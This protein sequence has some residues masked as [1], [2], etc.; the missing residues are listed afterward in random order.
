MF[1]RFGLFIPFSRGRL[2]GRVQGAAKPEREG[3]G[4]RAARSSSSN[5]H[6]HTSHHTKAMARLF[7]CLALSLMAV[8]AVE[9]AVSQPAAF[10]LPVRGLKPVPPPTATV[11]VPSPAPSSSSTSLLTLGVADS[12]S[13]EPA[14]IRQQQRRRTREVVWS[15]LFRRAEQAPSSASRSG[16]VRPLVRLCGL[17]ENMGS[18][19][20]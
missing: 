18:G 14:G 19:R 9:A 17:V 4:R 13:G 20:R 16:T 2:P 11:R 8:A 6:L 7:L 12:A 10:H 5:L 3:R 1:S 15:G